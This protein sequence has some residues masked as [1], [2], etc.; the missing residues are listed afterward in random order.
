MAG[1]SSKAANRLD[2]KFEYN[3]KEKQEQ[4]FADGSG[5]D[6]YDYG[7]RMYDAQIGRW[8][9]VDPLSE[10][11]RRWSPYN[12]ALN[13]PIRF[14]DPDGMWSR[15]FNRGDAGFDELLGSLQNGS[16]DLDDYGPEEE[17]PKPKQAS[18]GFA[19]PAIYGM[20]ESMF[21][22]GM[23]G[24]ASIFSVGHSPDWLGMFRDVSSKTTAATTTLLAATIAKLYGLFGGGTSSGEV[25]ISGEVLK[26]IE[27]V[28]ANAA[29]IAAALNPTNDKSVKVYELVARGNGPQPFMLWGLGKTPWFQTNMKAGDVW[30]YG[31]TSKSQVM[32]ANNA[33]ARY[34]PIDLP[35]GANVSPTVLYQGNLASAL[36]MEKTL[37]LKYVL[38]H[39]H[40]PPGNAMIK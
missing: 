32:G 34:G 8:N 36:F 40:L 33:V 37:I 29:I 4:E 7:A 38:E 11:G 31:T 6:W 13:N 9:H 17:D 23:A 16:F 22:G 30:K 35:T 20:F 2:N 15:S 1:I 24:G 18:M 26:Q 25:K 10:L 14:I 27:M 3:G 39:G 28:I 21:A 5:L 12:Y 19:I